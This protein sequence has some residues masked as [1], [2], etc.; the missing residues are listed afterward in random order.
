MDSVAVEANPA[1]GIRRAVLA[2]GLT[3]V[4]HPGAADAACAV[5]CHV[6][7]GS[8]AE[9]TRGG[10]GVAH[11][12]EHAIATRAGRAMADRGLG[13]LAG[14]AT[15]YDHTVY[16]WRAQPGDVWP[17]LHAFAESWRPDAALRRELAIQ[18]AVVLDELRLL[19]RAPAE[20]L[21]ATFMAHLFADHPMGSPICG[22]KVDLQDESTEQAA[23][24]YLRRVYLA[25]NLTVS[26][27]GGQFDAEALRRR[28]D[29]LASLM[30]TGP[31][32]TAPTWS[33]TPT[34]DDMPVIVEPAMSS[35]RE[36]TE[37][38]FATPGAPSPDAS[39]LEAL[40]VQLQLVPRGELWQRL[41]RVAGP[42]TTTV[43]HAAT[44]YGIGYFSLTVEHAT[45]AG[46]P[47]CAAVEEWLGG[48]AD[49]RSPLDLSAV[50]R[51]VAASPRR[52]LPADSQA[53]LLARGHDVEDADLASSIDGEAISG[54]VKRHAGG[55][56]VVTAGL[57][58]RPGVARG[59]SL[60]AVPPP[61]TG[62]PTPSETA[63]PS[64]RRADLEI[65]KDEDDLGVLRPPGH[66]IHREI[67][68]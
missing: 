51:L 7:G 35:S 65:P 12:L 26:V 59:I 46:D 27:V 63:R 33:P 55:G 16:A 64:T 9:G 21:H 67:V 42:C 30:P 68:L 10:T 28:L 2:G 14:A 19:T 29:A 23:L 50:H 60:R 8:L 41:R 4:L 11:L 1:R 62:P 5:A 22:E 31:A 15:A 47:V 61:G 48:L 3:L 57:R 36:L 18:R 24:G 58:R 39:A 45:G 34:V 54:A 17:S 49:G 56:R 66:P 44:N 25:S 6:R 43:H 52:S 40:A 13:V 53:K 37:I 20:R 32:A 38:G